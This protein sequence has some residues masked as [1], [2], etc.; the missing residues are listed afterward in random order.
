M[1]FVLVLASGIVEKSGDGMT[2]YRALAK[3]NLRCSCINNQKR[4]LVSVKVA[5][6]VLS[7]AFVFT[8]IG[9]TSA[10]D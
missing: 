6:G 8:W 3:Q 9:T 7:R 2:L 4:S 1:G 10:S 5:A